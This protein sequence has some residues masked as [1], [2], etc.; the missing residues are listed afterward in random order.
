MTKIEFF[1]DYISP[2][3]Y[4]GWTQIQGIAETHQCEFEPRPVLFAGLLNAHGQL[5]P[6]EVPAK[7]AY[8]IRNML[9]LADELNVPF[10][11][12][13]SHPFNPLLPLRITLATDGDSSI[14][15]IFY[16]AVWGQGQDISTEASVSKLLSDH[17]ID[18]MPLLE[19]ANDPVVKTRLRENTDYAISKGVF[20]VP[21]FIIDEELFWGVDSLPH[22]RRYLEG[23]RPIDETQIQAWES[24][25]ASARRK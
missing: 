25:P 9:W 8:V 22:L 4:L 20:G 23:H 14:I 3:A 11:V 12:P 7:R 2:Y 1:F 15:D 19:S 17:D 6:A 10:K 5:G 24:L 18:P 13:P 16:K 21:S